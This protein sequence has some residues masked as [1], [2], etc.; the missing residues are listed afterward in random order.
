MWWVIGE[1]AMKK[2]FHGEVHRNLLT[3]S[4]HEYSVEYR[5]ELKIFKIAYM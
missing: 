3:P 1:D 4:T 5:P 2:E